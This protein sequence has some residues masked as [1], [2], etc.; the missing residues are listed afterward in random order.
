MPASSFPTQGSKCCS[1]IWGPLSLGIPIAVAVFAAV[2]FCKHLILY[3]FPILFF[4]APIVGL[5]AACIAIKREEKWGALAIL[6]FGMNIFIVA[7][8]GF[9]LL[10]ILS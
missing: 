5:I 4:P 2:L 1:A 8:C 7:L 3:T 10:A 9:V 6:G